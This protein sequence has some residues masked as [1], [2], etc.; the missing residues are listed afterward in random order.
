MWQNYIGNYIFNYLNIKYFV[1]LNTKVLYVDTIINMCPS[2]IV[3]DVTF[4]SIVSSI[5]GDVL[6]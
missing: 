5:A 1:L 3:N 6:E 2:L 4:V